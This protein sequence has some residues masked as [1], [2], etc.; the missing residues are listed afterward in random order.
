MSDLTGGLLGD[1]MIITIHGKEYPMRPMTLGDFKAVTERVKTQ[2]RTYLNDLKNSVED[3]SERTDLVTEYGRPVTDSDVFEYLT[4]IEG[5]A[6][7]LWQSV[8]RSK[9]HG[10]KAFDDFMDSLSFEDLQAINTASSEKD[11]EEGNVS[12]EG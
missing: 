4:T 8:K 10:F 11:K 6:F 1:G 9:E 2:R 7:L 5:S 12:A 3:A